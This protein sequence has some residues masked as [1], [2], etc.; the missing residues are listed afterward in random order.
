MIN[1]FQNNRAHEQ[2][3]NY[4]E[5]ETDYR[6]VEQIG[7]G[8]Y[9]VAYLLEHEKTKQQAVFKRLKEKHYHRRGLARFEQEVQFMLLLKSLPIPQIIKA[10]TLEQVPFYMMSYVD[11]ETFEHAIFERNATFSLNDTLHYTK[12]LL[13]ILQQ[14][15]ANNIVHR[16]LRIA[17]IIV[18]NGQLTILDFGLATMIDPHFS[19][20]AMK[21]PKEA[22]HPI[23][24]LHAI[25]HFMLFLLYSTY[26]PA[27][28][29]SSPWQLELQLPQDLQ[30]F[31]ERLLTIDQPFLS[32]EDALEELERLDVSEE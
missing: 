12:K 32:C 25:G 16:D 21:N 7:E 11:G 22:P 30:R 17:N 1:F 3:K 8:S 24:D 28:K 29:K 4:I 19:I 27:T 14:M 20:E 23:S 6:L 18:K 2:T 15:H 9:G 26:K 5:N 13:E 31:I 10:G